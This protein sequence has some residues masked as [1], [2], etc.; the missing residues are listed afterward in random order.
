MFL[1]LKIVINV[2]V[3]LLIVTFSTLS[4]AE[5]I[6]HTYDDL[7]R[8]TNVDYGNSIIT[9]YTYDAAGNR[10]TMTT[11]PQGNGKIYGYVV[12]INDSPIVSANIKL[13]GKRIKVSMSTTTDANGF[14]EFINLWTDTYIITAKKEGYN[15]SKKIIKLKEGDVKQIRIV[16]RKKFLR[17]PH[18]P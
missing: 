18:A 16:M 2:F 9:K 3:I 4:F 6:T 14:F 15:D 13:K 5:T 12:D 10:L 7:N 8:L 17:N 11:V 1:R